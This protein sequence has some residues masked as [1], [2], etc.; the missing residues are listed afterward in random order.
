MMLTPDANYTMQKTIFQIALFL[1]TCACAGL[2]LVAEPP[3]LYG[4]LQM[5]PANAGQTYAAGMR[6]ATVGLGWREA[7]PERGKWN[8][9][10]FESI[11]Q[12]ISAFR[13]AGFQIMLDF[14]FQYAPLWVA[15]IPNALYVN[16]YGDSYRAEKSGADSYN[17][18]FCREVRETQ[19]RYVKKVFEELGTNF[20][21]VRLGWGYYGELNYPPANKNRINTYW[22]FDDF[23]Q[24]K[25]PGLPDGILPSPVPGWLPGTA[26]DN[27]A[28]ARSFVNWYLDSHKNW[29]DWQIKTV[30]KFFKGK[31]CM[32]YPSA[33]LAAGQ[34]EEAIATDLAGTSVPERNKKVQSGHDFERLIL[35]IAD[36]NVIA[37]GTWIDAESKY[38]DDRSTNPKSW[39]PIKLLAE[40]AHSNPL[41]LDVWGENTGRADRRLMELN[42]ER[43]R[44]NHLIGIVWA[45]EPDLFG[46]KYA[47]LE[48]Y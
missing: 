38:Y 24:G 45:F 11:R 47:T 21:W 30:R 25:V 2:P 48:D 14:G 41:H 35:G 8:A 10:Y 4:A 6:V 12:N 40:L 27:H 34:L 36:P 9:D 33:G 5:K 15:N 43:M 1:L 39:S 3:H 22:A 13:M 16:Q 44:D 20:G 26:S 31:L 18:V 32:L 42:F 29:H 17:A 46:G 19:E 7:E 37:Y 28:S 23:A